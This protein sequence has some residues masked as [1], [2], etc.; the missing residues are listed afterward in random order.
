[1]ITKS[2]AQLGV[3]NVKALTLG[4]GGTTQRQIAWMYVKG[5]KEEQAG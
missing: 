2:L 5:R 3:V 1:M 4:L